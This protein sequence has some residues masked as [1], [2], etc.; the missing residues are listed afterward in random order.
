MRSSTRRPKPVNLRNIHETFEDEDQMNDSDSFY[1][2]TADDII[3]SS[4]KKARKSGEN[5]LETTVREKPIPTVKRR[6]S[7]AH[8]RKS[9]QK[10]GNDT[11]SEAFWQQKT[12]QKMKLKGSAPSPNFIKVTFIFIKYLIRYTEF[13][14][15][16]SKIRGIL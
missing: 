14:K 15:K 8:R 10:S 2:R 16:K 5:F 13:T 7:A 9:A 12:P 4:N 6:P 1:D 11:E 3:F